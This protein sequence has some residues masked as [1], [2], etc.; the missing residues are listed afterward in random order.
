[1]RATAWDI[2]HCTSL[3]TASRMSGLN[4]LDHVRAFHSVHKTNY[5]K[6]YFSEHRSLMCVEYAHQMASSIVGCSVSLMHDLTLQ[7]KLTTSGA[8]RQALGNPDARLQSP[9]PIP[10]FDVAL[11]VC[12]ASTLP[13][14]CPTFKEQMITFV[15]C[16]E[17]ALQ[18]WQI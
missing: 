6:M 14:L 16:L 12:R 18:H 1:M 8:G 10:V 4:P 7:W 5:P 11:M 17:C 2:S 3:P 13:A 15:E 9:I